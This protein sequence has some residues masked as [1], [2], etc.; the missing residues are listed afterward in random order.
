MFDCKR[1]IYAKR[2]CK[3]KEGE[4]L[5]VL[6]DD[7]ELATGPKCISLHFFPPEEGPLHVI[8]KFEDGT[9]KYIYDVDE[10]EGVTVK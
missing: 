1:I 6:V 8:A 2:L 9:V 4:T 5:I 3:L 7:Q 10:V